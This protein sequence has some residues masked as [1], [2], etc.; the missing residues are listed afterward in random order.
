[1]PLIVPIAFLLALTAI[2]LAHLSVRRALSTLRT[3]V[4]R[5]EG[6]A[7][8]IETRRFEL[9]SELDARIK[10]LLAREAY[11]KGV[12]TARRSDSGPAEAESTG[13][14]RAASA[15]SGESALDL[16]RRLRGA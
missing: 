11:W 12:A 6:E 10:R 13:E 5:L 14:A 7:E 9:E 1:M 2:L 8:R 3:R 15:P 16:R 4:E